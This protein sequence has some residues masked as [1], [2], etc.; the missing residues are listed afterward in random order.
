MKV[1]ANASIETGLRVSAQVL[2]LVRMAMIAS[3]LGLSQI[4]DAY[5]LALVFPSLLSVAMANWIQLSFVG[6]YTELVERD[7]IPLAN[8]FRLMVFRVVLAVSAALTVT[9]LLAS[10]LLVDAF[11]SVDETS[12]DQ[13]A[14]LVRILSLMLLPTMVADFMGQT[15]NSHRKFVLS[16]V[17]VLLNTA[18]ALLVFILWQESG[19]GALVWG[20]L[21]GSFVQLLVVLPRYFALP[22][23]FCAIPGGEKRTLVRLTLWVVPAVVLTGMMPGVLQLHVA[24]LGAGLVAAFAFANRINNAMGQLFVMGLSRVLLPEFAALIARQEFKATIF[25]LRRLCRGVAVVWLVLIGGLLLYA[26]DVVNLVLVRGEF[27]QANGHLVSSVLILLSLSLLPFAI[28]TFVARFFSA[29]RRADLLFYSG[30]LFGSV[31]LLVAAWG[32]SQEN[33]YIVACGPLAAFTST[34]I[35]W[36][37]RLQQQME[38]KMIIVDFLH[39]L[40]RCG[41]IVLVTGVVCWLVGVWLVFPPQIELLI[42]VVLYAIVVLV[43]LWMSGTMAWL[44]ESVGDRNGNE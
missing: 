28:G 4:V 31:I 16:G 36:L 25:L 18:V 35:F 33:L 23:E 11:F 15:F 12:K 2:G 14:E 39:G 42:G 1:L 5:Y 22:R 27:S 30:L 26:D 13:T 44:M 7:Q 8:S 40:V 43:L 6:R 38:I 21:I 24:T 10:D 41:L 37:G 19:V 32:A 3:V 29:S 20:L 9:L 17:A 34:M